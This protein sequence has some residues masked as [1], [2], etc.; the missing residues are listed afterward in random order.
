MYSHDNI[1]EK[2]TKLTELVNVSDLNPNYTDDSDLNWC[3][4]L[5]S[6]VKDSGLIPDKTEFNMA[7]LMWKKYATSGVKSDDK[8][9]WSLVDM[10]LTQDNPTKIGAIKTYRRFTNSTL[11]DAKDMVDAREI[12]IQKGW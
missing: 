6:D 4:R 1:I 3:K 9:M 12:K 8:V 5:L 7:N 2:L 11:R 10:L